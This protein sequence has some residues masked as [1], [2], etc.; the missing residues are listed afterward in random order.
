[1]EWI[2]TKERLPDD[3]GNVLIFDKG[4]NIAIGYY[5]NVVS[6]WYDLDD[7]R[8]FITHWMPLPEIPKF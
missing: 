2:S 8:A 7:M 3:D 6:S 4:H 1:M 5:D